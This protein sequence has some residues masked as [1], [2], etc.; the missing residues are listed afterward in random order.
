MGTKPSTQT[1]A[2]AKFQLN[3]MIVK[4]QIRDDAMKGMFMHIFL[5]MIYSSL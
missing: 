4:K 2:Y 5:K 1:W 3:M